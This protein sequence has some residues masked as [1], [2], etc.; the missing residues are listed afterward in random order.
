MSTESTAGLLFK[1]AIR[2]AIR[3]LYPDVV[4]FWGYPGNTYPWE[5]IAVTDVRANQATATLGTRRSRSE[6][7][8]VDV[9]FVVTV[10]GSAETAQEE[11]DRRAWDLLSGLE[12]YVRA[13]DPTLAGLVLW[14]ALSNY[15]AEGFTPEEQRSAGYVAQITATFAAQARITTNL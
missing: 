2:D 1:A 4:V 7:L 13:A 10:Q 8:E 9:L 15:Q 12:F 14:C 5:A 6:D 3:G 11:A